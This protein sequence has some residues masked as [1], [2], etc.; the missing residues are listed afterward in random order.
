MA[1]ESDLFGIL[2]GVASGL[3]SSG[4]IYGTMKTKITQLEEIVKNKVDISLFQAVMEPIR[5]D[6]HE[7][8]D[9]LKD[10]LKTIQRH[11]SL[12]KG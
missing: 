10:L 4:A 7:M 12:P 5:N 11:D 8:K 9:D 6:I 1:S 2:S 3:L